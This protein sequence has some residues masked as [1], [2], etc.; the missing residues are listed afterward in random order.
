MFVYWE[1]GR[2]PFL[3]LLYGQSLNSYV[4]FLFAGDYNSYKYKSVIT[5]TSFGF[6]SW[7]TVKRL[8]CGHTN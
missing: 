5:Q 6:P 7:K 4:L 8:K 3:R 1:V 2:M